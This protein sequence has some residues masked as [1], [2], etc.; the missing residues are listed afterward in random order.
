MMMI[1]ENMIMEL[2]VMMD[3]ARKRQ[4][5]DGNN[6][7]SIVGIINIP[8]D[9]FMFHIVGY[10]NQ[11]EVVGGLSETNKLYCRLMR[12]R[13]GIGINMYPNDVLNISPEIWMNITN[14]RLVRTIWA[15]RGVR[16]E[17]FMNSVSKDKG[18]RFMFGE[19]KTQLNRHNY[20]NVSFSQ[21]DIQT[22]Q[23]M[24]LKE[25]KLEKIDYEIS[26]LKIIQSMETIEFLIFLE[27][28][29]LKGICLFPPKLK[30]LQITPKYGFQVLKDLP[31][32]LESLEC[33]YVHLKRSKEAEFLIPPRL[34]NLDVSR[35]VNSEG[36]GVF[37]TL[38]FDLPKPLLRLKIP[39]ISR[40]QA[41]PSLCLGSL[42][43]ID[44]FRC[45]SVSPLRPFPR[46]LPK[47]AIAE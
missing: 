30:V 8:E 47:L 10:L 3:E 6:N 21:F 31:D 16:Y 34:L 40:L 26:D 19:V 23:M 27:C 44:L 46:S 39:H 15:E 12:N 38:P 18:G 24:P 5:Q 37:E 2:Q 13:Y 7:N 36:K 1:R 28:D 25:L 17:D 11:K 43:S 33:D 20:H 4:Q 35:L 41:L 45:G 42:R 29:I 32:D 14:V 22:L 9:V